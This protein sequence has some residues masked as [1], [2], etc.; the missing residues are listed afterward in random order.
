MKSIQWVINIL[1][2]I[3][4]GYLL[5]NSFSDE[6]VKEELADDVGLVEVA[7]EESVDLV[8]RYINSD[9]IYAHY[10]MVKDLR[11]DL[12]SRQKQYSSSLEARVKAF[13]QEVVDFQ[14]KAQTMSQF[15]GQQKQKELL[16]KEQELG[17]MQQDLSTKL[18]E[19]ENKMQRD[20]RDNVLNYLESFKSQGVDLVLDF[21][22]N[23]SLLMAQDT[24][25]ISSAVIDSLNVRYAASKTAE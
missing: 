24:F 9:S 15:E 22:S 16:A 7:E 10:E 2:A 5:I 8:V 4:L 23:S 19:M 11:K 13:E 20:I 12:E 18:L 21:S 25:D 3:I 14:Q 1:F 6:S 17:V